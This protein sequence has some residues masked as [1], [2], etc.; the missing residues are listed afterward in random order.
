M[1]ID[2]QTGSRLHFGLI[3]GSP[4][5]GWQFGG[6]GV[7]LRTPSWRLS[8]NALATG[9]DEVTANDEAKKRVLEFVTRIRN[10]LPLP[11]VSIKVFSEVPFHTG[12]GSGTQLGLAIAAAA[13]LIVKRQAGQDPCELALLAQRAERSAI[14]TMGFR[15]GG[16]LVD[17]GVPAAASESRHMERLCMPE[18]WRFLLIRPKNSQGLSGDRERQFFDQRVQMPAPLVHE[19]AELIS[20]RLV[21]SIRHH[22][23]DEFSVSLETYGN[24][25]GNF[26]AVEQGDVFA[27]PAIRQLVAQLRTHGIYGAAQSSWGPGISVPARSMSH[28]EA[29]AKLIPATAGETSF[30][31]EISEPMNVGAS[32]RT[33]GPETHDASLA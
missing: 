11:P 30:I 5:T 23:F 14:G 24:A 22:D 16:F 26:Y 13:H 6:V 27:H 19:L 25:V 29:I 3:C 20:N 18:A 31:V 10:V 12:L 2:V 8:L 15:D 4:N 21:P 9:T 28:A 1:M 32:V 33:R 17:H 7:M